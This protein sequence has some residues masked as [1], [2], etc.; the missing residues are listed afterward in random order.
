MGALRNGLAP[1]AEFG[2]D[3]IIKKKI[4]INRVLIN[5]KFEACWI[6][7]SKYFLEHLLGP[8]KSPNKRY[9]KETHL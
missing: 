4:Q 2:K 9:P 7:D 5:M 6:Y 1:D 3:K 8:E